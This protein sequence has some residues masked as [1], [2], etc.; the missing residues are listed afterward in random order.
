M[1]TVTLEREAKEK[2]E[3]PIETLEDPTAYTVAFAFTDSATADRPGSFTAGVWKGPPTGD[4][5]A[6]FTRVAV[7]PLIGDGALDLAV[8]RWTAW[9]QVTAGVEI[10]IERCGQIRVR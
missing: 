1:A 7:T 5:S 6:G 4:A 10:A 9:S 8:G 3:L 2:L